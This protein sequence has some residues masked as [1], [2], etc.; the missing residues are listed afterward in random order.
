VLGRALHYIGCPYPCPSVLGGHGC[1]VIVHG[2]ASVLCI[3]A[4]NS[5]SESN[6]SDAA[7]TLTKRRSRLKPV[8]VNGLLFVRSNQDLVYAGNTHYIIFVHMGAI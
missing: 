3:L 4:S 7:N 2:W 8:T 6:F 5:K 1:D